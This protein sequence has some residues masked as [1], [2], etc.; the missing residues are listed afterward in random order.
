MQGSRRCG[1]QVRGHTLQRRCTTR[2]DAVRRERGGGEGGAGRDQRQMHEGVP[3]TNQ[4]V[5]GPSLPTSLAFLPARRIHSTLE[6]H[7]LAVRQARFH[8]MPCACEQARLNTMAVVEQRTVQRDWRTSY[9]S[10][11]KPCCLTCSS[12]CILHVHLHSHDAITPRRSRDTCEDCRIV[13][14]TLPTRRPVAAFQ[15]PETRELPSHQTMH[16]EAWSEAGGPSGWE[17][18]RLPHPYKLPGARARRFRPPPL[19]S[20][21]NRDAHASPQ[22]QGRPCI[23]CGSQEG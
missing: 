10:S 11:R 1:F 12:T 18:G 2:A 15:A 21:P 14:P 16:E 23:R 20:P 3:C 6:S 19:L 13:D 17:H 22:Q 5:D 4:R 9:I 7:T 8:T